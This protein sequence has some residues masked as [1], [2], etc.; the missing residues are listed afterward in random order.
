MAVETGPCAVNMIRQGVAVLPESGIKRSFLNICLP[1]QQKS[2][3]VSP[4]Y[5]TQGFSRQT[6]DIEVV[7]VPVGLL[8]LPL[9]KEFF[10]SEEISF[11][12]SE[13]VPIWADEAVRDAGESHISALAT[14]YAEEIDDA[15]KHVCVAVRDLVL[16]D[17]AL[18][19][20]EG[21]SIAVALVPDFDAHPGRYPN[22]Q[23][24]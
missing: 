12:Q 16:G 10:Q 15:S 6:V 7:V 13:T 14:V 4:Q 9:L 21:L 11:E 23:V 22:L 17:A 2:A 5:R 8:C 1:T 18:G 19:C 24:H 20:D 3:L